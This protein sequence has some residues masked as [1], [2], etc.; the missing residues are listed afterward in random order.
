MQSEAMDCFTS[1]AMTQT[2]V[3]DRH[4]LAASR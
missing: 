1:F 4:G 3:M 2:K